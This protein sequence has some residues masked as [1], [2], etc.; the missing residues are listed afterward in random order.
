MGVMLEVRLLGERLRRLGGLGILVGLEFRFENGFNFGSALQE[1]V[2]QE[3]ECDQSPEED[4][5][6]RRQKNRIHS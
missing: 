4:R 3:N 5:D 1:V 2:P 6:H